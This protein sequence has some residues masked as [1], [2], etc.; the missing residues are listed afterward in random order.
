MRKAGLYGA[1][2]FADSEEGRDVY[3]LA[4]RGRGAYLFGKSGLGKTHAAATAVR[5]FV[6]SGRNARLVSAK[7]LLD[8]VKAGFD[9]KDKEALDRAERYD[10]LALD[11]L[12]AEKVTAWTKETIT[13]LIGKREAR[14]LP[15]VVTS[16][17]RIGEIRDIWGG[18]DGMRIASRLAG[19]CEIVEFEG[20]DM[21]LR[22]EGA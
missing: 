17:Y 14:R 4:M 16:N 21:R 2:A 13:D 1:Y 10:L 9:G 22:K 19:S 20:D 11:D 6:E 7:E 18:V 3:G 12:G 5:L 15:T 8:A